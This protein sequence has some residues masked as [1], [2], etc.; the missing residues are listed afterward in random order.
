MCN[1]AVKICLFFDKKKR[2]FYAPLQ[3][4]TARLIPEVGKLKTIHD[5]IILFSNNHSYIKSEALFQLFSILTL[6]KTSSLSLPKYLE[7]SLNLAYSFLA[8]NRNRITKR[9]SSCPIP[10]LKNR[11]QFLG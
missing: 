7:K 9:Y 10:P 5:S 6:G 11:N 2:L 1:W 8:K 4:E 3:G